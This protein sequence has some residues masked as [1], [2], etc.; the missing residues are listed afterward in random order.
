M[1]QNEAHRRDD[2]RRRLEQD[3]ALDQRL[4][5]QTK[6]E[7][8]EVAQAAMDE[9]GRCRGG[10]AGEIVLLEQ[11]HAEAAAGGITGDAAAIDPAADHRE[12]VGGAGR[13]VLPSQAQQNCFDFLLLR[14]NACAS[15]G[16]RDAI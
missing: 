14:R 2:V 12:I 13:L 10:P 8:F 4:A 11:D 6:L 16:N 9:L 1:G 5:H 3:F 15:A 7:M